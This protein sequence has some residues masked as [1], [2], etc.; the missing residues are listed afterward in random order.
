MLLLKS[1]TIN[2]HFSTLL[3]TN[4]MTASIKYQGSLRTEAQH[5]Q[6]GNTLITDAPKDNNGKGE[7][8][9][10][11]DLIATAAVSCMLTIMGI[12]ARNLNLTIDGARGSVEKV[13]SAN[14]RRIR[15]LN[16]TI[17]IPSGDISDRQKKVL[18]AVADACPV[19]KS[20]HPDM[21]INTKYDWQNDS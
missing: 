3:K 4:R 8:F 17:T 5:L 13:M 9:S 11:T 12:K 15:Q 19:H 7:A 14:P 21:K 1:R 16:I 18:E 6:S 10:P 2:N 20:L